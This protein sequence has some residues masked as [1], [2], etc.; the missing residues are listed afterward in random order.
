L[1][2]LKIAFK[3]FAKDGK[4]ENRITIL[5]QISRLKNLEI[6]FPVLS[7]QQKIASVLSALDDKLVTLREKLTRIYA[8]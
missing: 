5:K 4:M 2:N 7:T 1:A 8:N 3:E 6:D